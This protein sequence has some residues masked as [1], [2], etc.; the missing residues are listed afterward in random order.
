M[1]LEHFGLNINPFPS[2]PQ[3]DFFFSGGQRAEAIDAIDLALKES[4]G[5]IKV[6]GT[7][8]SG[9]TMLCRQ[10]YRQLANQYDILFI[11]DPSLDSCTSILTAV[12]GELNPEW[13]TQKPRNKLFQQIMQTLM[14]QANK[15]KPTVLFI[16]EA[17]KITPT[18]FEELRYLTNLETSQDKLLQIVLFGQPSLDA[19][20]M[21]TDA[22]LLSARVTHSLF[23]K[24]FSAK[25]FREYTHHRL[26]IAG[27]RKPAEL[28][29][30]LQLRIIYFLANGSL[31][32]ANQLMEK[33]LF[34]A[35]LRKAKAVGL[36]DVAVAVRS[37]TPVGA[38]FQYTRAQLVSGFSFGLFLG[39]I[40]F[41]ATSPLT[42]NA[43]TTEQVVQ[44]HISPPV[45][46]LIEFNPAWNMLTTT[47][48][49]VA[50][51]TPRL[52]DGL[53]ATQIR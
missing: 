31:R 21:R 50:Y 41:M 27:L 45:A 37:M 28:F 5:I 19:Q 1:Y 42:V 33:A 13:D 44:A 40:A 38:Q 51:D 23:I 30:D 29:T 22:Q 35:F 15:N 24:P 2:T 26:A 20:L 48:N 11:S 53:A 12:A 39:W 16:E 52:Y 14:Q 43:L 36:K 6:I 46:E 8:G 4:F 49:S 47:S 9:K 34:A 25:V 32:Y 7:V 17:Q 18:Q 10:A 3:L